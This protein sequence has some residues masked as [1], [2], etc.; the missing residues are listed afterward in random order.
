[1]KS[2][3]EA[4]GFLSTV[5]AVFE[6]AGHPR[7]GWSWVINRDDYE[8]VAALML[9][10]RFEAG[11]HWLGEMTWPERVAAAREWADT[12]TLTVFGLRVKPDDGPL[13]RLEQEEPEQSVS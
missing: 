8:A 12:H 10:L 4:E 9:Q 1:M 13:P 3:A 11:H 7:A 6:R 5:Q 2:R